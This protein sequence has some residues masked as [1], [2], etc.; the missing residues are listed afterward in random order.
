MFVSQEIGSGSLSFEIIFE[1][2]KS[3]PFRFTFHL[4]SS[5][6]L[7]IPGFNLIMCRV[8]IF[9]ATQGSSNRFR[10]IR[11]TKRGQMI[12]IL[13]GFNSILK[14]DRNSYLGPP[15]VGKFFFEPD[16]EQA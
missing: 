16:S 12:P 7:K 3:E 1:A 9:V 15:T 2:L 8:S 5:K 10:M 6:L 4:L 13:P 14:N 11:N